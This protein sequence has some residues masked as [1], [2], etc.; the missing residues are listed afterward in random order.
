[1]VAGPPLLRSAFL[2]LAAS[3]LWIAF[4]LRRRREAEPT[5]EQ[6]LLGYRDALLAKFDHQIKLLRTAKY[7][8]ILPAWIGLMLT[9]VAKRSVHPS[10]VDFA[11]A[12][13]Y[14]IFAVVVWYLNE[15]I[16]VR[17]LRAERDKLARVEVES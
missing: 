13:F 4:F 12:A 5:P 17:R 7:W 11:M 1:M 14:T 3:G 9:V 10:P 8:Y 16:G 2:W 6:T 15:V